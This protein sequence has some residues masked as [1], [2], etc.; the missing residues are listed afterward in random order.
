MEMTYATL[1][2]D[3]DEGACVEATV[4]TATVASLV[5]SC[6]FRG[7]GLASE[8]LASG[9]SEEATVATLVY[10]SATATSDRCRLLAQGSKDVSPSMLMLK[11]FCCSL[12]QNIHRHKLRGARRRF[13]FIHF[14]FLLRTVIPTEE[15]CSALDA[16][17]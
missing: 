10:P 7:L 2:D 6:C 5:S 4:A 1:T 11:S 9:V 14:G 3:C 13:H 12:N 16:R 17:G 15:R 8:A